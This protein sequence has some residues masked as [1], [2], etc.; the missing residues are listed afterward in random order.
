MPLFCTAAPS[1]C[2]AMFRPLADA[3]LGYP[4]QGHRKL[5][6]GR[7][8]CAGP[9]RARP[10]SFYQNQHEFCRDHIRLTDRGR[11]SPPPPSLFPLCSDAAARKLGRK[12]MN[13]PNKSDGETQGEPFRVAT[14]PAEKTS[15]E[16]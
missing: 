3:P 9:V 14:P 13:F 7:S 2:R 15:S 8:S 6:H 5:S 16:F 12:E 4:Q 11:N 1:Q 10:S